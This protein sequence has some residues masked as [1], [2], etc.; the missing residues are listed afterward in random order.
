[1][2]AEINTWIHRMNKIEKSFFKELGGR[3][4]ALR[5]EQGLTQAHL[6]QMLDVQQ[7][8]IASYEVG[9]R[10]VPASLLPLLGR[11][12][13]ISVE[14]LMGFERGPSKRGPTPKLQ[15]QVEQL[16]RLPKAKQRFVSELLDTVLQQ[17]RAQ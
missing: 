16:T 4:K 12:L 9:R 3:I 2:Q 15:R 17:A 5:K 13:G 8:V 10:R 11:S 14:E 6:A 7:Q 1:M